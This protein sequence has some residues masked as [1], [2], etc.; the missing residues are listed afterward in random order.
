MIAA[1]LV[2]AMAIL[3]IALIL[4]RV[5]WLERTMV[6]RRRASTAPGVKTM[7]EMR[8]IHDTREDG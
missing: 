3:L 8:E 7:A 4:A 6:R 1:K 5:A 2:T